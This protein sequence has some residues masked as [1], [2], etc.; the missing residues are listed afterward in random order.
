MG[1]AQIVSGIDI[2]VASPANANGPN[3]ELLGSSELTEGTTATNSGATIRR[4]ATMKVILFGRELNG[5]L[6]VTIGGPPDITISNVRSISSTGG[7]PGIAFDA[8]VSSGAAVGARTVYLR[9]ANDD[10]TAFAGG[11]EVIP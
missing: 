10:I 7:T 2:A 4:G 8:A 3:A 9:S 5:S 6:Q 1:T 11:L